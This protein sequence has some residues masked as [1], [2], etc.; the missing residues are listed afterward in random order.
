M[1]EVWRA[2]DQ[3]LDRT[4]AIKTSRAEFNDRFQRE[5]LT[6][7]ALSHPHIAALFDVGA[8]PSGFGYLVLEYVAGPTLDEVIARGPMAH[9]Q[10]LRMAL[11]IA[12]AIEAAHDRGIVHRDLKPSNIKL[13]PD[14]SVKV[15]DFG[16]AKAIESQYDVTESDLTSPTRT[17]TGVIVGTPAYMSPEQASGG[18]IDRRTDI[19]SFGVIV[20][21][22]LTGTRLFGAMKVSETITAVLKD[23]VS[24]DAVPAEWR[25][26]IQRCLVRDPRRRLQSIGEARIAL[27]DGLPRR[28]LTQKSGS[29]MWPVATVVAATMALSATAWAVWRRP[30]IQLHPA[31]FSVDLGRDAIYGRSLPIAVSPDGTRIVYP[32]KDASGRLMLGTRLLKD[33]NASV[34]SKTENGRDPFFSP[35]GKW[36][37]FFADGKLRKI[38]SQGGAVVDVANAPD[39]RGAS[40]SDGTIVAALDT[41]GGLS[42]IPESGGAAQS[43]TRLKDDQTHR[44]PQVLPRSGDVVFTAATAGVVKTRVM[45]LSSRTGEIK[46]LVEDAYFGRVLPSGD[47]VYLREGAL[48]GTH[49]DAA[50][51]EVIGSSVKLLDDVV[52]DPANAAGLFDVS[53]TGLMVYRSGRSGLTEYPVLWMDKTGRTT[54][55]VSRPDAYRFP[56]FSPDGQKI[57]LSGGEGPYVYDVATGSLLSRVPNARSAEWMPDG[58]HLLVRRATATGS[59]LVYIREDGTGEASTLLEA[60]GITLSDVSSDGAWVLYNQQGSDTAVDVWGLPLDLTDPDRPKPGEARPLLN[61]RASESVPKLSPD[62]RWLAYISNESGNFEMYVRSFP[63][64]GA[65]VRVSNGLGDARPAAQWSRTRHEFFFY[66]ADGRIFVVE[67]SVQGSSFVGAKPRLWSPTPILAF[68][69]LTVDLHPDGQRFAVYPADT[70]PVEG[71]VHLTFL[72][73]FVDEFRKLIDAAER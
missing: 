17:Q 60:T 22:M 45:A 44:W 1:G 61:S 13:A 56:K 57:L 41:S 20:Y 58:R 69:E 28:E 66:D 6:I 3:R 18:S 52:A 30:D 71:G 34:L 14:G 11:Q 39:G 65:K 33:N 12:E 31:R 72:V 10:A 47:L 25:W 67:Y 24:V 40:W 59:A 38:P 37:G 9:A 48:W 7:A 64:L 62:R 63:E 55:L 49:F 50:R 35:D 73:D 70:V 21:E 4:V 26:L 27:E 46:A 16:L 2:R 43:I 42:R 5:A 19:W 51:L 23:D 15:L 68:P 53:A 36:I 54:T 8:G 32:V 29:W